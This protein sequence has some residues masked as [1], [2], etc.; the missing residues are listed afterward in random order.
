MFN[1]LVSNKF[2]VTLLDTAKQT[3]K[4]M[5]RQH[6]EQHESMKKALIALIYELENQQRRDRTHDCGV[7]FFQFEQRLE[8]NKKKTNY[9]LYF[10]LSLSKFH[11]I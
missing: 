9:R 2:T 5:K 10:S 8:E 1:Q 11:T 6:T 7:C 3:L 4:R